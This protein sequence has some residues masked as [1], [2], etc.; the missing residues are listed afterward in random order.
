MLSKNVAAA[1]VAGVA[2]VAIFGFQM[3]SAA[4][5][6]KVTICHATGGAPSDHFVEL[7]TKALTPFGAEGHI[8]ANGT[9][10]AGHEQDFII[11]EGEECPCDKKH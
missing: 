4:P 1:L 8:D 6:E 7:S 2:G 11:G 9:P 10:L 3:A 5:A